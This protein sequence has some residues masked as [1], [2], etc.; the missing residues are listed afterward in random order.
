MVR[1]IKLTTTE[2]ARAAFARHWPEMEG[3]TPEQLWLGACV[4]A[5]GQTRN[6]ILAIARREGL[7]L[8]PHSGPM[9]ALEAVRA[10]L[11]DSAL[12]LAESCNRIGREQAGGSEPPL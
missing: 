12:E 9:R 3:C 5:I 10:A 11:K 1:D 4:W 8:R 6:D 7:T 2:M